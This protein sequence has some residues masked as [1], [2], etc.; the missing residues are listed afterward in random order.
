M[1]AACTKRIE[2]NRRCSSR[3]V[4]SFILI[5]SYTAEGK[6]LAWQKFCD[7]LYPKRKYHDELQRTCETVFQIMYALIQKKKTPLHVLIAQTF[8]DTSR[9]K[10]VIMLMNRL[11]LSIS[12]DEMMRIDTRLAQRLI[13]EAGEFMV[14]VGRSIKHGSRSIKHGVILQDAM[15]NF[16]DDE[17]TLSGKDSSHDAIVMLFQNTD[18]KVGTSN[19]KKCNFC[20]I[21]GNKRSATNEKVLTHILPISL[22]YLYLKFSVKL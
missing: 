22:T 20:K 10:N 8:R 12:Y 4:T 6:P 19:D 5:T 11:G 9:S 15:D 13:Q 3:S 16:D 21:P 18:S 17:E 1:S 14:H 7:S 2:V